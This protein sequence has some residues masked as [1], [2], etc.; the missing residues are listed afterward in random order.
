MGVRVPRSKATRKCRQ[1][2]SKNIYAIQVLTFAADD[3]ISRTSYM[4]PVFNL[5]GLVQNYYLLLT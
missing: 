3:D 1:N 2:I 5:Y 4:L